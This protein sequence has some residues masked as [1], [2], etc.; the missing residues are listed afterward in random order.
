MCI[1]IL[2]IIHFPNVRFRYSE[3]ISVRLKNLNLNQTEQVHV[4]D[5][6]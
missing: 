4:L 5:V 6:S 1:Y 3:L 2:Y